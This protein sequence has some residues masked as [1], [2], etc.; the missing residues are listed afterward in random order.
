MA[1]SLADIRARLQAQQ[2]RSENGPKM[3]SGIYPHWNIQIGQT[4]KLRFLPDADTN[5][6]YFWIDR[7]II[8]LP[9]TGIKGQTVQRPFEVHVPCMEMWKETCPVLTE[10]R[11][12]YKDES[13]KETANKYWKKRSYL[14]QGFVR[15][16]PLAEDSSPENPIRRFIISSQIYNIIKASLLDPELEELPVHYERGLDFTVV[17]TAKSGTD[18]ADYNT[19]KWARKESPLTSTELAALEQFGLFNLA[20]FLP[21][22]PGSAEL[23]AISELFQASVNGEDYDPARWSQYFKP[24]GVQLEENSSAPAARPHAVPAAVTPAT[25]PHVDEDEVSEP[26]APIQSPVTATKPSAQKAEDILAAIR[27]R[28]KTA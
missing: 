16:N 10:V 14:F 24:V 1:L 13:L 3:D 26:T 21:K 2:T 17:K 11:P 7:E 19:S 27:N 23:R 12:W 8:K 15:E 20:D 25:V 28:Q 18:Y 9:F 4:A 5:N 22:K 6:P